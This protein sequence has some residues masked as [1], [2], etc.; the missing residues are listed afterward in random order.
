MLPH[1]LGCDRFVVD[2]TYLVYSKH[3][4]VQVVATCIE[5]FIIIVPLIPITVIMPLFVHST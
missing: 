2:G 1:V 4:V 3:N 5:Y